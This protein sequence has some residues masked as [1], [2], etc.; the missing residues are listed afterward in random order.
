MAQ[1]KSH[2]VEAEKNHQPSSVHL[3]KKHEGTRG[4]ALEPHGGEDKGKLKNDS[5]R[6]FCPRRQRE[7]CLCNIQA[8]P[9]LN[10]SSTNSTTTAVHHYL[11]R[12]KALQHTWAR[13][14]EG[15]VAWL[16]R[17][18]CEGSSWCRRKRPE[19]IIDPPLMPPRT[20]TRTCTPWAVTCEITAPLVRFVSEGL[21]QLPNVPWRQAR[22]NT[23]GNKSKTKNK[24]LTMCIHGNAHAHF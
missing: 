6:G 5:E 18:G 11:H 4:D 22:G 9:T 7:I 16:A 3:Q 10:A 8:T 24:I 17:R 21:Y 19:G 15:H 12:Y 2:S 23:H 13:S 20:P 1:R 14:T